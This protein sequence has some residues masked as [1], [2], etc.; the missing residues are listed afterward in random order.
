MSKI[1]KNIVRLRGSSVGNE[2]RTEIARGILKDSTPLPK[3]LLYTDIDES[4]KE[5]VENKLKITFDGKEIPTISL[6]SNQRFSEYMQSWSNVDDK[7]NL[8]LNFKAI[9]RENNP[10]AGTIVGQS[11]NIPGEHSVVLKT[12]EA[13]DKNHRRYFIDYRMKQPMPIDLI[14]TITLLTN[15]YELLNEFNIMLNN[16]FKSIN[17]YIQPNGHFIPMKLNDISDESEYNIDNRTYYSQNY[18]ITVMAYIMPEN[19]FIVEEIPEIKFIGF[20]GDEKKRSYAEIEE[21]PC[22]MR[23]NDNPKWYFQPVNIRIHLDKCDLAYK[24]VIDIPFKVENIKL[25]NVRSLKT[26]INDNETVLDENI[27]LKIGDEIKFTKIIRFKTFEESN[28]ILEGINYENAM[29]NDN[30]TEIN[31]FKT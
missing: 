29:N 8:I 2:R 10:K 12:V 27:K 7:K 17:A 16:E 20:E 31:L 5:W 14:Y 19:S 1:Y 24:F 28:I 18:M 3:T 11:R 25:D 23:E 6:F 9:S 15:K 21:L 30:I 13:Y 22:H 26:Y 4:F